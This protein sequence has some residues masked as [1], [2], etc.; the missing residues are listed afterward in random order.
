MAPSIR[1]T[2]NGEDREIAGD[3]TRSLLLV[4]R[5]E[6][7]LTGAK[8]GC[9]EGACGACTVLVDGAPV[10]SCQVPLGEVQGRS[11]TTIEGLTPPGGLHPVQ[12]AF[13]EI[14]AMQCGYCTPGM[15]LTASALLAQTPDPNE[16]QIRAAMDG[17]ICRCCTYPRILRAIRQAS[18][19][20]RSGQDGA[21]RGSPP[22]PRAADDQEF[23]QAQGPWDLLPPEERNYFQTLGD[24]LV[25]IAPAG[26]A[27]RDGAF[28]GG[29]AWLHVG[30]EDG[31]IWA[32]SGKADVGQETAT[33]LS[34]LVAEEL[35]V[36]S[37]AVR[38]VM[39]D[40]DVCPFDMGTFGSRSMPDAAP[41]MRR[42][43]ATARRALISMAAQRWG[44]S[45]DHVTLANGQ[46][47]AA[48]SDIAGA[49]V[50]F[51]ELLR[52]MWRLETAEPEEP[53]TPATQWRVAGSS[54]GNASAVHVVT[55]SRRF[56][57]DVTRPGLLHGRVL[58]APALGATLGSVDVRR[59]QAI[60]GVTV[61]HEGP[62]V[63]VV[64]PDFATATRA[65]EILSADAQ[66]DVPAH[67]GEADLEHYM[68]S[69]PVQAQDWSGGFHHELGDA[70][71]ALAAA[72]V[73]LTATY[74]AAYIAHV[75]LETRTAVA[76]WQGE[77]LTVWAGTQRPFGVR[78]ELASALGIPETQV[79]V[80]VPP[81]GSGFGGK[82]HGVGAVEAA[83]L[84]RAVGRPVKVRWTRQ[85]EFSWGYL[86]PAAVID[87]ESGAADDGGLTAWTFKNFNAGAAGI[88]SP[89]DIPH[90][91]IQYQ[92]T[93][94]PLTQG[95]YRA[96][97]AT[98][99]HFARE[100]H[101]DELA[102]RLHV[103]PL[104]F[105]LRHLRDERLATVLRA[106]AERAGWAAP[107][108][109]GRGLGIAAGL[110]KGGRLAT[111][112]EVRVQGDGRLEILRIVTA[113]ECGAIVHPEGLTNQIEGA[114]IMGLGGALFEGIHFEGGR[115]LNGTL[116]EYRVPRFNDIPPIEVV[117]I[118]R[119]D[120]PSAGAGETPIVGI[121][122]ALANAIFAAT[123][124]RLRAMPLAPNGIVG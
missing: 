3:P 103:D 25:A 35:G 83:R 7:D 89:Y 101:M 124:T 120:L 52:G 72:P 55:G 77:R 22:P 16:A 44:V 41:H 116:S 1:L 32:F 59:A 105:R 100:S 21:V 61:L 57:S 47:R 66:W 9:G 34:L 38:M 121:A 15:I 82:H 113:F 6:L 99:N 27:R 81:T 29:G 33:A 73:R 24:G 119:R 5:D 46:V 30:A 49:A 63:G 94:A 86:R 12:A 97:A 92:P 110:E 107:R 56:P 106:A 62:F 40:T 96:L 37:S 71:G 18:E 85:E 10:C 79:R 88:Q 4:L 45:P 98:A 11:V 76:Q 112:A 19:R 118:D 23:G 39:A 51:Q 108:E 65:I 102:H 84:A 8:P 69:H 78:A 36:G 50:S 68:R 74:T 117:L 17:H 104:E 75:P 53:A 31:R 48:A 80:R 28:Q 93:A 70:D 14:G 95:S 58:R 60:P 2:L 114:T 67:P 13:I 26:P 87:I 91:R 90:Q 43:A 42:A 122:P 115:L 111:C 54:A 64:A 109:G 20:V 123:G